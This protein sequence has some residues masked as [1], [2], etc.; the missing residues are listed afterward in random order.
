MI[1]EIVKSQRETKLFT[2]LDT[3]QLHPYAKFN[4]K[5]YK[6]EKLWVPTKE[7]QLQIIKL[8]HSDPTAGHMGVQ[9]TL[10]LI[11][12]D[13]NW[14]NITQLVKQFVYSCGICAM[15]KVNRKRPY[16]LLNPIQIPKGP[17][18][19]I[20]FDTIVLPQSEGYNMILVVVDRLTK[21][22]HFIKTIKTLEASQLA[23][24]FFDE[25]IMRYGSPSK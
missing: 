14:E 10:D 1:E 4:D 9:K 25:I 11:K 17:W 24:V 16:G 6:D 19:S 23:E 15:S 3:E 2:R 13:Y 20:T 22:A 8:K 7:L 5:I 21:M 18:S 12:R